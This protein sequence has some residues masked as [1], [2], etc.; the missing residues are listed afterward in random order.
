MPQTD[1]ELLQAAYRTISI[2]TGLCGLQVYFCIF[3]IVTRVPR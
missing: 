2:L 1:K 3:L